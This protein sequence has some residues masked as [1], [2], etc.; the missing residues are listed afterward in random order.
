MAAQSPGQNHTAWETGIATEGL[1]GCQEERPKSRLRNCHAGMSW[2]IPSFGV[3]LLNSQ[4]FHSV[5]LVRSLLPWLAVLASPQGW[6]Y[7]SS[8]SIF[9]WIRS[10]RG[11]LQHPAAKLLLVLPWLPAQL[12]AGSCWRFWLLLE[13]LAAA[14]GFGCHQAVP[15]GCGGCFVWVR[16]PSIV[17]APAPGC[18]A[19]IRPPRAHRR[20][21]DGA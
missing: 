4:G 13:V 20:R 2:G 21:S 15:R 18:R 5:M 19:R 10:S 1:Q 11:D 6:V 16:A 14:G 3:N 7:P 17:L 8:G 12:R 9:L